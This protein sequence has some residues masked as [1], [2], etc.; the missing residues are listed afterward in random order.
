[1]SD[2]M[3]STNQ[4]LSVL[5]PP[6]SG[7]DLHYDIMIVKSKEFPR[8][9][10]LVEP[11]QRGGQ[12]ESGILKHSVNQFQKKIEQE[13]LLKDAADGYLQSKVYK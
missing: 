3:I 1:M 7:A 8:R 11:K 12:N 9:E 4:A 2:S 10:G 6:I 13:K 5:I